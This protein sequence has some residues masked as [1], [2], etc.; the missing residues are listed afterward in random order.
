MCLENQWNEAEPEIKATA[1]MNTWTVA[2]KRKVKTSRGKH[3]NTQN[4]VVNG[5]TASPAR[6]AE[7][8][9]LD[10]FQKHRDKELKE[11]RQTYWWPPIH[12]RPQDVPPTP[13]PAHITGQDTLPE[14]LSPSPSWATWKEGLPLTIAASREDDLPLNMRFHEEKRL[15]F[16]WTL[17]AGWGKTQ[18]SESNKGREI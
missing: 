18:S 12:I 8:N 3:S 15:D 5:L 13:D 4:C 6:L 17:K 9:A 1:W 10:V 16:E 7:D 11:R 14:A 2:M